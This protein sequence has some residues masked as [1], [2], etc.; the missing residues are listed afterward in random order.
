MESDLFATDIGDMLDDF[1]P[2]NNDKVP[3]RETAIDQDENN[4][5]SSLYGVDEGMLLPL[6]QALIEARQPDPS[7]AQQCTEKSAR[8]FLEVSDEPAIFELGT[9]VNDQDYSSAMAKTSLGYSSVMPEGHGTSHD[10]TFNS[11]FEE[12]PT[13]SDSAMKACIEELGTDF[14]NFTG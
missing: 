13:S 10:K 5:D 14:F 9:R 11:V 4:N 3:S 1:P 8:P 7:N 2:V 12:R 6:E